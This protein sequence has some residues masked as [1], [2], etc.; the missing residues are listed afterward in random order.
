MS[1]KDGWL[2]GPINAATPLSL[3][4]VI[5]AIASHLASLAEINGRFYN[6][7]IS[8]LHFQINIPSTTKS[9][10]T[11]YFHVA[12]KSNVFERLTK[13]PHPRFA[14]QVQILK[15]EVDEVKFRLDWLNQSAWVESNSQMMGD[16]S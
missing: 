8:S 12:L 5:L 2:P 10:L 11:Q 16:Q 4:S 6:S 14:L 7:F 1:V 15:L 13:K 3:I 9:N